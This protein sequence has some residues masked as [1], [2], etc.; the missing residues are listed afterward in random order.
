LNALFH[1]ITSESEKEQS[2]VLGELAQTEGEED[3]QIELSPKARFLV[4]PQVW[5]APAS[6][7]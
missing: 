6:H 5:D 2:A 4:E 3:A 1:P 7:F